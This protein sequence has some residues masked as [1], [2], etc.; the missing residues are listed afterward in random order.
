MGNSFEKDG[1]YTSVSNT[2]DQRYG[3]TGNSNVIVISTAKNVLSDT[4]INVDRVEKINAFF[5]FFFFFKRLS[6]VKP[7]KLSV[8]F[9]SYILFIFVRH[10]K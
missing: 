2:F 3:V 4:Y 8:S 7:K 1:S 5:P 6:Y 10:D 9:P